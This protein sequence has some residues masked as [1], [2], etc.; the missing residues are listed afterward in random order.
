MENLQNLT[1]P[2]LF[3]LEKKRN[4]GKREEKESL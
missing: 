1:Y 3:A 4:K 2:Y